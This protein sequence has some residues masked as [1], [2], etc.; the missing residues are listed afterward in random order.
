[1]RKLNIVVVGAT[2]Y[3]GKIV[4]NYLKSKGVSSWG[5]AGRSVDKLEA[6]RRELSLEI[7]IFQIDI[8]Q[9]VSL[10][11]MC[12]ETICVIACAGPFTNVGMPIVDAC[13]RCKTHYVDSTGEFNYVRL[14]AEK[15]HQEAM[16]NGV[17]LV[18][19][20]GFDSVPSDVGN[21]LVHQQA[22]DSNDPIKE[23]KAYIRCTAA[24]MS[25][26]TVHSIG[27]VLEVIDKKDMSPKSL[28]PA[29]AVQP[30][31]TPTRKGLWYDTADKKWSCPFLMA[32][33]NERVVRR[34]N[35]LRGSPASYVEAMEGSLLSTMGATA[36]VYGTFTALVIPMVRRFLLDKLYPNGYGPEKKK[37]AG[38][39][40]HFLFVGNTK[41]GRKVEVELHDD[42]E[43][44]DVTGLYLGECALSA[45]AL[46]KEG[47]ILPGVL[48]PSVA[49][50]DGLVDRLKNEGISI[51]VRSS[52]LKSEGK[53]K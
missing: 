41:E 3:T 10:D 38:C 11:E 32:G 40:Y 45:C 23:V 42:R 24:G 9:T 29:D 47:K 33:C 35:A 49:F 34:S 4:C 15:Y 31:A 22:Q 21:Y 14:V 16:K 1:M 50:G 51:T 27:A 7:P 44:Y 12:R 37:K 5:I 36:A 26:G 8:H 48:T 18:S 19:C 13:M 30:I 2:G 28:V 39:F 17:L 43:M 52:S 25:S 53:K 6:L 20:C 46:E